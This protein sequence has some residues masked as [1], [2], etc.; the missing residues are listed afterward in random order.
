MPPPEPAAMHRRLP[1][2]G[3][4]PASSD[5]ATHAVLHGACSRHGA[6]NVHQLGL[7]PRWPP[8]RAP[9]HWF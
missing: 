5:A 2:N 7:G 8:P 4:P 9:S 6:K 3:M 1:R